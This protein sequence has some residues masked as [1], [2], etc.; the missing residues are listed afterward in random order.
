MS[1]SDAPITMRVILVGPSPIEQRLRRDPDL[2]LIRAPGL[3]NAIGELALEPLG[4]EPGPV[5]IVNQDLVRERDLASWVESLRRVDE[6][7]RVVGLGDAPPAGELSV[8]EQWLPLEAGPSEL[9]TL[10]G[11]SLN[12]TTS[13]PAPESPHA[14]VAP[15][16]ASPVRTSQG[17]FD[18][19][20]LLAAA[21]AAG[22]NAR[23][24]CFE[25]LRK[26]FGSTIEFAG[27]QPEGA[28]AP[29]VHRGQT[30]GW[31]VADDQ[32]QHDLGGAAAWVAPWLVL[33]EQ[34]AQL[35]SAAFTDHLTGAWNRR[36]FER[37][38]AGAL[39]RA[40]ARRHEVSLLMFDIDDFKRYNDAYG[41][42]AGDEILRETVHLLNSVIRPTDRVARIGGD[43]FA[44]VFDSPDGPREPGQRQVPSIVSITQRFQAQI[45]QHHFPK[46]GADAQGSLTISGGVA[47]FPWDGHD[48]ESLIQ[49][50]DE[51]VL[52]SKRQGKNLIC[53]GP[54]EDGPDPDKTHAFLGPDPR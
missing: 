4:M 49:R 37:F 44:V 50:A 21:L 9:R 34:H 17:D 53:I 23:S 31:L 46:L 3:L 12:H 14:P 29:V 25:V 35:R 51:L 40:R 27:E 39:E 8:I 11:L 38:L 2:E 15:E 43:E 48:A 41:H 32:Q 45:N 19:D 10:L 18:D 5:V 6:S 16:A 33:I 20:R 36:Y 7:V 1:G 54:G 52:E 13:D 26:R 22:A 47:T 28:G 42:P 30:L 24:M